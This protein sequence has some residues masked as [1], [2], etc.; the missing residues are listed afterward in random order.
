MAAFMAKS[1]G[2][3]RDHVTQKAQNSFF[4]AFCRKSYEMFALK[5]C[6]SNSNV[7]QKSAENE[8]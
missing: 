1:R 2:C 6:F 3:N 8:G 5:E 7:P 4:L